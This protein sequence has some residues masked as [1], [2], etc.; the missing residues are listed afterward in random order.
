[1]S[2]VDLRIS[3]GTIVS[4]A[5]ADRAVAA[6]IE[7]SE[8]GTLLPGLI[9]AHVH[10]RGASRDDPAFPD[11]CRATVRAI[12]ECRATV[13]AGFTTVRDCG[14]PYAIGLRDGIADGDIIGP[15]IVAAGPT[16]SQ[17]GGHADL[18]RAPLR[19]VR[20]ALETRRVIVDGPDACRRGVREVI[21]RGAD[22]IKI[23][24]SGGNGSSGTHHE[25][26]HFTDDEIAAIVDEAH[27]SG[28]RVAA[29][30][31]GREAVLNAV[32][33]AVDTVEHGY[34][35]DSA[36][37]EEMLSAGTTLV[38]TFGLIGYFEAAA[39]GRYGHAPDRLRKQASCIPAMTD[40]FAMARDAGIPIAFGTDLTGEPGREHGRNAEDLA[41]MVRHGMSPAEALRT[42]TSEAARAIGLDGLVG[43]LSTGGSADLVVVDGDP[44]MDITRLQEVRLVIARGAIVVADGASQHPRP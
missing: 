5:P 26:Q 25:D 6:E 43:T 39:D 28:R 1:M 21:R 9:D 27:R 16:I 14:G 23:C 19:Y 10:I 12:A 4:I 37:I 22:L 20:E 17:T 41:V 33:G 2:D 32:R 42:A 29:H 18:H 36:C 15:R 24:T 11:P 3:D 30:A 8:G 13:E 40:A 38:P 7:V 31:T 44:T 34:F 35:L